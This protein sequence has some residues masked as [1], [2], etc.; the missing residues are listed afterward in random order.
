MTKIWHISAWLLVNALF[1]AKYG[2]RLQPWLPLV[3]ALALTAAAF[4]LVRGIRI[5]EPRH[6]RLL[7]GALLAL[8]VAA[9]AAAF[10]AIPTSHL[11]VDRFDMIALFWENLA[12]GIDPYTPRLAGLS[13]NIP[14]QFPSYFLLALPFHLIGEVGWI[15]LLSIVAMAV[16]LLRRGGNLG[17]VTAALLLSPALWW[18]TVC[19]ST[20]FANA[21]LCLFALLPFLV[22]RPPFPRWSGLLLGLA[23][24]TRSVTLQMLLPVLLPGAW[25][26]PKAWWKPMAV[27][28]CLALASVVLLS[29]PI[30]HPWTPFAVNTFFLPNW[31][32][33][34]VLLAS[35]ALAVVHPSA[36]W[37][38]SVIV[39]GLD[40]LTTLYAGAIV[41]DKGWRIALFGSGVDISYFLL[42]APIHLFLLFKCR[43]DDSVA[44]PCSL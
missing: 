31:V 6:P 19:R 28:G 15:P 4:V 24:G 12:R 13:N 20:I 9:S 34:A 17:P 8:P 26:N 30:F 39:A 10:H 25:K 33:A 22:P 44:T 7:R 11:R 21:V 42:G 38:L 41:W 29:L 43:Q 1:L 14:S 16:L 3:A 37:R 18:E 36:H 27:A 5:L 23:A 2:A 40:L 35:I 32:A